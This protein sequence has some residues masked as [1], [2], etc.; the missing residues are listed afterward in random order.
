MS[1]FK[2]QR[3]L[4]SNL[5]LQLQQGDI[6]KQQVDAIVNAAN[7]QLQHGGG[8][9]AAIA[10]AGGPQIQEESDAWI[11][12]RGPVEHANPAFTTGG[13]LPCQHVIHAVGPRWGSGEEDS[14][15]QDAVLGSLRLADDLDMRSIAFPAISTGIFGFPE[16]RAAQVMYTAVEMYADRHPDTNL[17]VVRIVLFD[18][19][20]LQSFTTVWDREMA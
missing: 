20:T 17:E 11:E 7:R 16:K 1:Q 9:A 6:T 13:D 4:S 5:T 19:P 14:K 12:E 10:R 8:V 3:A 2:R 18:D 15:L